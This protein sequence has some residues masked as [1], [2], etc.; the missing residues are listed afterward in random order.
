MEKKEI[1]NNTINMTL[2]LKKTW[3]LFEK[4]GIRKVVVCDSLY[5]G[6]KVSYLKSEEIL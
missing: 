4:V 3:H 1:Y 6:G 2:Y 5:S